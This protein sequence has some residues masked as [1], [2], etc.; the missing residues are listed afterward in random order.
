MERS[1]RR[2]EA[3]GENSGRRNPLLWALVVLALAAF[4][5]MACG[6]VSDNSPDASA[7]T[8]D[9]MTSTPDGMTNTPDAMTNTPDATTDTP[10]ANTSCTQA[11]FG[12]STFGA[13]CFGD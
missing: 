9:G 3:T 8:S 7:A 2:V 4:G 5:G 13:S 12:T 11:V 10:D 6:A 1:C